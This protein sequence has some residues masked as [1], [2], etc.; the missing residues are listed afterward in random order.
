MRPAS[1]EEILFRD[2]QHCQATMQVCTSD[3]ELEGRLA[4]VAVIL[5]QGGNDEVALGIV[6]KFLERGGS[7]DEHDASFQHQELVP[8]T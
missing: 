6:A 2:L 7:G 3:S 4:D 5:L 8:T 1:D